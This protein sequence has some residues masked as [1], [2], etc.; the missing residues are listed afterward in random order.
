MQLHLSTLRATLNNKAT[1]DV[2]NKNTGSKL[3]HATT[4]IDIDPL[5]TYVGVGYRF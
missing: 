1:I 3:I 4:K 2:V 5:S